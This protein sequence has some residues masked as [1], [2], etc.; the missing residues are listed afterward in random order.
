MP[1]VLLILP[2][3]AYRAPDFVAAAAAMGVELVI[4]SDQPQALDPAGERSVVLDLDRPEAGAEQIVRYA[5]DRPL[6]AI[7][8]VDDAGVLTST[9]AAERL[10]LPHNPYYAAAAT[11]DKIAMRQ[12]FART[13]M[14]QPPFRVLTADQDPGEVADTL[15]GPVVLKPTCLS[16]SRG[17]I[18]ADDADAARAAASRI[19]GILADAGQD[20]DGPLLAEGFVPG[21]EVAVE[22]MLRDG[23]FSTL[24]VFDKPDPLDGPY[25]EET[26]YVTPS[27]LEPAVLGRVEALCQQ[28]VDALGLVEGPVHA[29]FRVDRTR[30]VILE[31]AARSIGGLC[32]R[33]LRFGIG[34]TLEELILRHALGMDGED[35]RREH[36]ASGVMMLPIPRAGVLE[37]VE[38]VEEARGVPGI[39][40]LEITIT[41]GSSVAPLP[42][43]DRYLGFLF[44]RGL[45]PE[46]VEKSLRAAHARLRI[47]IA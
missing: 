14:P 6:E 10:E 44:A 45:A 13:G 37:A 8:A 27:R 17:V 46:E 43:A 39:T 12:I 34:V 22:G 19:R 11:R 9:I 29:E 38:G 20:K 30:V 35:L 16:G 18:R 25:F 28:A 7:V 21:R 4:G 40:G 47:R 31:L 23:R 36:A 33:A 5:Q 1:R 32:G 3:G 41:P 42:D 24:A 2:S 15:G 26:I